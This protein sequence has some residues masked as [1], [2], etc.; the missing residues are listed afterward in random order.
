MIGALKVAFVSILNA[1]IPAKI[2]DKKTGTKFN[3]SKEMFGLSIANLVCGIIGGTPCSGVM[4]TT[5]LNITNGAN[6]RA[7]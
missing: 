5:S 6:H 4:V 3:Q 2:A 7:S 1:Y